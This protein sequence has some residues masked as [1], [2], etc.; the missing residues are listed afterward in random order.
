MFLDV[1]VTIE[2]G[3]LITDLYTKPT[4]THQNLKGKSCHPLHS[5]R[6]LPY[7]Q[8]LHIRRIC[9]QSSDYS[10]HTKELV[11]H[12]VNRGYDRME[13]ERQVERA[14]SFTGEEL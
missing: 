10:H 14:T 6:S 7:S 8:A 9:L 13:V 5:K 3:R 12:L 4:D 2:H 1:K 11:S